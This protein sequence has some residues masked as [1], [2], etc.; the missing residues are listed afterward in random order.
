MTLVVQAA[1][2]GCKNTLRIPAQWVNQAMRCKHCGLIL[3]AKASPANVTTPPPVTGSPSITTATPPTYPYRTIQ[4][5]VS[6]SIPMGLPPEKRGQV[7]AP[8]TGTPTADQVLFGRMLEGQPP[9]PPQLNKGGSWPKGLFLA[10]CILIIAAIAS[11]VYWPQLSQIVAKPSQPEQAKV[12]ENT[13]PVQIVQGPTKPPEKQPDPSKPPDKI[14]QP[15]KPLDPVKPKDLP[16]VVDP[17]KPKE[18]VKPPEKPKDPIKPPDT[19]KPP[20]RI[21]PKEEV[22]PP[23]R[24]PDPVPQVMG[25]PRR[26]LA[27]S[28]NNY[29]FANPINFG[30]SGRGSKN[31]QNLL[32][33]LNQGLRIPTDQMALLSDATPGGFARPPLKPVIEKAV[34]DF[35]TTSR[36]QDR[37]LVLFIGHAVEIEDE[38]YL[39]PLEGDLEAKETLIPL[40]WLYDRLASSKARQKVL[41]LDVCRLNPSRGQERPGSGP[42]GAKL[43]AALKQPP[44]GVQVWTAC[45]AAQHSYEF[46]YPTLNNGV[47]QEALFD[48]LG[49]AGQPDMQGPDGLLPIPRLVDLVNHRLKEILDKEGKVQTSRLS[50]QEA[51]AGAAYDSSQPRPPRPSLGMPPPPEGGAATAEVIQGIL[52][53]L[54]VLPVKSIRD[55]QMLKLGLMPVF[56]AKLMEDYKDDGEKTPFREA[57]IRTRD[58][59]NAQLKTKRLREEFRAPAN[60]ARFKDEIRDYQT[61]E[62]AGMLGELSEAL[63]ELKIAA[64]DRDK[65]KSK[66]WQANYDFVLARL[67]MQVAY[68]YEY[69]TML[70][71]MRKELPERDPKIHGGWRLASQ[72]ALQGDAAGK[73]LAVDA[74][75]VLDKIAADH[76]NTPWAVIA[77]REKFAALGLDWQPIK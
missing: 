9:P 46:E 36:D 74:R 1:C 47:F 65:E 73:R 37:I 61:K 18:V 15:A 17:E 7:M 31:V 57:I 16:K 43:D 76:P 71:S 68:L 75:K 25:F 19:G 26:A 77:K 41:V 24:T 53:E 48:V 69:T 72:P 44:P 42:L 10:S 64:K 30:S 55:D 35:I 13:P 34:S 45:V 21:K 49:Q 38:P 23:I 63:D 6:S 5:A 40:K 32:E 14:I 66:R 4:G 58:L 56:A 51:P 28:V 33:R 50:G 22:K 39:V 70:G 29:L 20:D 2:P 52:K 3:Q 11:A 67:E 59:L 54:E 27:I 62:V 8:T 60:E 12:D